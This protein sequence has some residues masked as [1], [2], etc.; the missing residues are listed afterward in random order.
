MTLSEHAITFTC[1][2]QTLV[3]VATL[4][5]DARNLGVIVIVGGPQYRAGSHRQFV[6]LAR[7][8]AAAGYP[9]LRFDC[10]GMG[11]SSGELRNF[12]HISADIGSAIN[13][14]QRTAPHVRRVVLWGLCDGA[15]AALLYLDDTQ[16]DPRV[17]GLCLLNPWVR[18]ETTLA[19]A[20]VKHYYVQRLMQRA[21]WAKLLR[22]GVAWQA[23]KGLLGNLH[24]AAA[25]KPVA[26]GEGS[27]SYT[28]RMARAWCGFGGAIQLVLSSRDLTAQEFVQTWS[29]DL[30]WRGARHHP[31]LEQLMLATADHTLSSPA[32]ARQ[33]EQ[34]LLRWLKPLAAPV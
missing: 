6:Q 12:E 20:H 26:P 10:R 29:T 27:L 9:V 34:A 15:S 4:P 25:G 18:S 22:G 5:A 16:H 2:G 13:A 17:A 8:A 30:N 24:K 23:L 19:R 32:D 7:C 31:R 11:D 21:F 3:G 14:L 1:E 33:A 28:Q